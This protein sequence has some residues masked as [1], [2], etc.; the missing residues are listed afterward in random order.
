MKKLL[1]LALL[2]LAFTRL[3]CVEECE[4]PDIAL[5]ISQAEMGH[6]DNR[7]A[8]P[9][10]LAPG[11]NGYLNAYGFRVSTYVEV[12]NQADTIGVECHYFLLSPPATDCRI[13]TLTGTG[14]HP[15]GTD[16]SD[17]FRF[18]D[19]RRLPLRYQT[20]ADAAPLV[21]GIWDFYQAT[22]FDFLLAQPPATTGWQQFE[23]RLSQ[24]DTTTL[25][26]ITDSIF[27]Q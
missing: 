16:V 12:R 15:P 14:D 4:G 6:L 21:S 1:L 25:S 11:V 24:N 26:V 13:F 10:A 2:F 3:K 5:K 8:E 7:G 17:L 20:T 22:N 27:L 23:L 18:A 9:V 19:R